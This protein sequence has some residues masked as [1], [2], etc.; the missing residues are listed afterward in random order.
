MFKVHS[1]INWI[2]RN[3]TATAT[4]DSKCLRSTNA[5]P[6]KLLLQFLKFCNRYIFKN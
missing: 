2:S 1:D 5:V 6:S 3:K 4:L